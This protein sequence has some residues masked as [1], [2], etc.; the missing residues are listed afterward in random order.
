MP[1]EVV[2]MNADDEPDYKFL[3]RFSV[4]FKKQRATEAWINAIVRQI[5]RQPPDDSR[6]LVTIHD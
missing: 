6:A 5:T 4:C 2:L 3:D 1:D